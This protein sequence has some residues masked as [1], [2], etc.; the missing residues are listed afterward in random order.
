MFGNCTFPFSVARVL[1]EGD[2]DSTC[3]VS[4]HPRLPDW[5]M[6][7]FSVAKMTSLWEKRAVVLCFH[8]ALVVLSVVVDGF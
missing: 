5:C 3:Y 2:S 7:N 1:E 8:G 4:H 6:F